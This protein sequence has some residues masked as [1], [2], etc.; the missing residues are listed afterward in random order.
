MHEIFSG[1]EA[2]H[3]CESEFSKWEMFALKVY[4]CFLYFHNNHILCKY[5]TIVHS[6]REQLKNP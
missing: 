5:H 2:K 4:V 1:L 6:S 3:E